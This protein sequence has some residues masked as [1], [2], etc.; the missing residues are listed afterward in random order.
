MHENEAPATSVK[1]VISSEVRLIDLIHNACE[2]LAK[3]AGFD[4][5]EALNMSLAVRETVINAIVH[6]NGEDPNLKVHVNL[7]AGGGRMM[8]KV[9][10]QGTGFDPKGA[11]DPTQ[12][13]NLLRTAGRGLLLIDAFVDDVKY[14][15][16]PNQGM[17]VTLTKLLKP[18]TNH[19]GK[20]K[21]K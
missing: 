11:A 16:R 10:D 8:A 14:Q 9:W 5:D 1:L 3:L 13:S 6:G 20:K 4:A 12:G 18:G 15:Q 7:S 2:R 17:E 21:K 19:D